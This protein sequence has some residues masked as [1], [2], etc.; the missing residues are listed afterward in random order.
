MYIL[1]RSPVQLSATTKEEQKAVID[2]LTCSGRKSPKA[3]MG[4]LL[5]NDRLSAKLLTWLRDQSGLRSL[6]RDVHPRV[7]S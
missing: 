4:R 7:S 2:R 1:A 3:V 6:S 5:R